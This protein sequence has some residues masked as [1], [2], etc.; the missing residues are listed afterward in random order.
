[1]RISEERLQEIRFAT[2]Q[3]KKMLK[4][5]DRIRVTRCPGTRRWVIFEGWDGNWIVSKSGIS[6]ICAANIDR[7]N[8]DA[9]DFCKGL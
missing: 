5:G 7:L 3:A 6:D 1:M 8:G 9:V 4:A 2:K